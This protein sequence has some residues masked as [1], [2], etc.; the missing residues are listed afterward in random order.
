MFVSEYGGTRWEKSK[1]SDS[2][3]YGDS[4][5][6]EEEFVS[7]LK[8]LTDAIMDNPAI[9]GLCY[10]QLYDIEQEANGLYTYDREPKFGKETMEWIRGIFARKAGIE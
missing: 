5:K 6:T 9:F 3:G 4:P 7:R 1:S 2:W 8:G 10:T